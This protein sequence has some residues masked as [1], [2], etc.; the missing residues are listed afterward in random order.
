MIGILGDLIGD[1][2]K[3]SAGIPIGPA[4]QI[5]R[6]LSSNQARKMVMMSLLERG[7][8]NN[9]LNRFYDDAIDEFSKLNSL[10][11]TYIHGLWWTH[12]DGRMFLAEETIDDFHFFDARQV[13]YEEVQ[14]V[15]TR[16]IVLALTAEN[17]FVNDYKLPA[18]PETYLR[19]LD[20]ES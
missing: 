18:S 16:M 9:K 13:K 11:N 19:P 1:F 2:N 15:L 17:R 4:R 6:S 8:I 10:R 5:F 7:I 12:E 20:L 3:S 14:E